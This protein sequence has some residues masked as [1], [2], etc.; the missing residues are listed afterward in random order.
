[1]WVPIMVRATKQRFRILIVNS[2]SRN[3]KEVPIFT[4]GTSSFKSVVL[5][6]SDQ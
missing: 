2:D 6:N 3:K 5:N 1:M 4:T